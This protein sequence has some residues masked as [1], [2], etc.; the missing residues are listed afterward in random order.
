MAATDA[1]PTN[2]GAVVS[3][4]RVTQDTNIIEHMNWTRFLRERWLESSIPQA[5]QR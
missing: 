5:P 1:S 4:A 2:S 3:T